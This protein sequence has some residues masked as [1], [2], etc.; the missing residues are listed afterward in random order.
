MPVVRFV[1]HSA[2]KENVFQFE[3][4]GEKA[5]LTDEQIRGAVVDERVPLLPDSDFMAL[6]LT[7]QQ[8]KDFYLDDRNLDLKRKVWLA[9]A[10]YRESLLK[11]KPV[12]T[13]S[14][15]EKING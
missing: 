12:P 7:D 5:D 6:K 15:Q 10:D 3:R 13:F 4:F 14:T 11:P 8:V 1:G 2:T 9:A